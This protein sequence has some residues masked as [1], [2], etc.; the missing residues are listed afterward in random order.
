M[1]DATQL[2]TNEDRLKAQEKEQ[3]EAKDKIHFNS[4]SSIFKENTFKDK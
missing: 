2:I 1:D 3:R 4:L